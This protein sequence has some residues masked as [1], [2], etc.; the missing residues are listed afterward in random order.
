ML[1][2]ILGGRETDVEFIG[3][4]N[5]EFIGTYYKLTKAL[6]SSASH[7]PNVLSAEP[8]Q[9]QDKRFVSHT[10]TATE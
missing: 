8:L 10:T 2:A 9:E 4:S 7:S 3:L 5:F 1:Y 6:K